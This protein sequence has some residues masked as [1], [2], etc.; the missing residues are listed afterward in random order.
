MSTARDLPSSE[1]AGAMDPGRLIEEYQAGVWRYLRALG[2][3]AAEADDLTQDTFVAVLQRPFVNYGPAATIGYLRKVAYNRFIT[4]RRRA[5]RVVVVEEID[6]IDQTWERLASDDHGEQLL[7]ALR[8]C[9]NSLTERAKSAL[10]MRFRDKRARTDIA[11]H[12]GITEHGAK[13]LM[14]RAKKQLRDCV[15][16]KLS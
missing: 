6:Q 15:E 4:A 10:L 2:C 16:G 5:G 3:D 14:Q 1:S 7:D 13:N 8:A 12:L 11:E 9:L